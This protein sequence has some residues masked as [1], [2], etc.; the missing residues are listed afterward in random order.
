MK[1]IVESHRLYVE[2]DV[3]VF[4]SDI[5]YSSNTILN[6]MVKCN[7]FSAQAS[8]DIDIKEFAMF[9][10]KIQTMYKELNGTALIK[11]PYGNEQFIKITCDKTGHIVINGFLCNMIDSSSY[12]L[13]FEKTIDQT[14]ID[15]FT[16]SFSEIYE[17]YL[18][19]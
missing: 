18:D 11:E 10:R 5:S 2:L 7:E 8:M 3:N 16:K 19:K 15:S 1:H 13:S 12:K 6:I 9:A 14:D 4:E 17:K